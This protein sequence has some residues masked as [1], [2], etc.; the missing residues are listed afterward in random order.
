MM[1]SNIARAIMRSRLLMWLIFFAYF[2]IFLAVDT[3]SHLAGDVILVVGVVI[4]GAI[5]IR[6]RPTSRRGS[7]ST[8]CEKCEAS[9]PSVAGFPQANCTACGHR[10]SWARSRP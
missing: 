1:A 4:L 5:F 2:A 10:Q 9:L 7:I 6:V 8:H 3:V